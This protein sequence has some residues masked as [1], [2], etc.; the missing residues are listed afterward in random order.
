[1]ANV[2]NLSSLQKLHKST[3]TTQSVQQHGTF[4]SAALEYGVCDVCSLE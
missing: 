2:A 4:M 3:T 1:M